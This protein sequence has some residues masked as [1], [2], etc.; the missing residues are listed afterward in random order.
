MFAAIPYFYFSA[1]NKILPRRVAQFAT[2]SRP[3][4]PVCFRAFPLESDS[5]ASLVSCVTCGHRGHGGC[6]EDLF[7]ARKPFS[8]DDQHN[9][10]V[11]CLD[12]KEWWPPLEEGESWGTEN[13]PGVE[14]GSQGQGEVKE[15]EEMGRGLSSNDKPLVEVKF[16]AMICYEVRVK[17]FK[18]T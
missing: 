16:P 15:E 1:N 2:D 4:C 14:E 17:D 18:N 8:S 3:V 7:F 6:F 13:S 11:L 5:S 12:E 9:V 10:C